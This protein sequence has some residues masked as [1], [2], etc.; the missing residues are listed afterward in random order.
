MIKRFTRKIALLCAF[1]M[2]ATVISGCGSTEIPSETTAKT[3]TV[4]AGD[5]TTD[6]KKVKDNLP[7]VDFKGKEFNILIRNEVAYEFD[8]E[9]TGELV[10][11][12]VY[13]RNIMVGERFN[14]TINYISVP[15]LWTS[16]NEYQSLITNAVLANDPVYDIVTGQS[17]VIIPMAAQGLYNEVGDSKYIDFSK[18]YWKP[19]YHDNVKINDRLYTLCGDYALTALTRSNVIF[20][21]KLLMDEYK[22]EYPYQLVKEGNWTLDKFL[23]IVTN[24]AVDLNGDSV[25]DKEDLHGFCAYSNSIDPFFVSNGLGFTSLDNDGIRKIDFPND[26]AVDVFDKI[27]AMTHSNSFVNAS[28]NYVIAG[29]TS[30][31]EDAMSVEFKNGKMLM[32]GMVLDGVEKLRDMN[33]DFGL[34]PYPKY[35]EKQ[36]RYYTS[37]TRTYTIAAIPLS[38]S[39]YEMPELLLEALACEGYNNIVPT[40]YEIAL[41]GKYTRDNDSAEMLDIVSSTSW[42]DFTDAYYTDLGTIS[43]FISLYALGDTEGLVSQFESKR[44]SFQANLDKLYEAYEK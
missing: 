37:V 2:A 24:I 33:V 42:F 9:Q 10:N 11:D 34:I 19:G 41:K 21:N 32:M 5:D 8:S 12:A 16:K 20:F 1:I 18:P 35:D 22:I 27:Y 14:T 43:S 7:A 30:S 3:D 28:T 23:E 17:N 38:A 39:D 36:E 25:I 6:G 31:T 4:S 40:Y 44:S 15:G 13:N 26:K 29:T